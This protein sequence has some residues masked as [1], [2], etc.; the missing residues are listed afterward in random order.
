MAAVVPYPP[1]ETHAVLGNGHT[2]AL[3]AS[4]GTIDWFCAPDYDGTVV[5]GALLDVERGG[6]WRIGPEVRGFGSQRYDDDAPIVTTS[7]SMSGAEWTVTDALVPG[8]V[9]IRRVS[10]ARGPALCVSTF[11]PRADFDT[12]DADHT[13]P[14]PFPLR[15]WSSDP[16]LTDR[17]GRAPL[18]SGD[19]VWFA[20]SPRSA[21]V[22]GVE[23]VAALF[24]G[25]ARHWRDR[26][27]TGAGADPR[28]ARSAMVLQLLQY[29]PS[30]AMVAAPTTSLPERIGGGWNVDYR[31]SWVRDTS[32]AVAMLARLGDT[33]SA[34]RYLEWL[35]TVDSATD[36]PLQ[37]LYDVRGGTTPVRR[38][39]Y[40]LA[41][42][43]GSKPVRFGNHA[44]KQ[45]QLDI[46]GYLA[47]AV[48]TLLDVGGGCSP[49]VFQL[50][51]RCADYVAVCW[52]EPDRGI[53][54]LPASQQYISSRVMCWVA[55]DRTITIA[56]RLGESSSSSWTHAGE[57]IRRQVLE[58]GWNR[59]GRAFTQ[60]LASDR[61]D[62]SALLMPIYGFLPA[63]DE[64]IIA[65]VE[66]ISEELTIDGFVYRF[67]P[68]GIPGVH[69]P[70]FGEFEAAFVPCTL[71][72]ATVLRM[73]RRNDTASRLIAAIDRVAGPTQLLA[74]AIDA[75]TRTFAGNFPL[76]FSHAEY[77]R[78]ALAAPG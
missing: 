52:D 17:S 65:T 64:R 24:E 34:S 68:A 77:I 45:R 66:R 75:R 32:I 13:P 25:A 44:Y 36:A 42:Y 37:T 55:L 59:A 12:I 20:L 39:Q 30:G 53:W 43:R 78:A 74:E 10:C 31:L 63:D 61:L 6:Y 50:L 57:A 58:R 48:L 51:R 71:W 21:V 16:R 1:I 4:D 46:F 54:E 19:V 47:D 22:D 7:W 67:D 18:S 41:G 11:Q 28:L 69:G 60:T 33:A 9:L 76:A 23:T 15:L 40:D 5:F 27:P 56:S 62:A 29:E 73:L 72:L 38:E 70:P 3:V 49:D 26:R 8:P 35:T 14:A 2:A